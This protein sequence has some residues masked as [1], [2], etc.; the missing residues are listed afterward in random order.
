MQW[1]LT[2][3]FFAKGTD[4]SLWILPPV[5]DQVRRLISVTCTQSISIPYLSNVDPLT[6]CLARPPPVQL[7]CHVGQP[8]GLGLLVTTPHTHTN[9][10]RLH[11]HAKCR[12]MVV[13]KPSE[14]VAVDE[15]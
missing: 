15:F 4:E 8:Y 7:N 12:F 2:C 1:S 14:K 11:H 10:D 5:P 3:L 13:S 6:S 9:A